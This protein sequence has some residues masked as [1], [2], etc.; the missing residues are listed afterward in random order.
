MFQLSMTSVIMLSCPNTW[1]FST[2][3]FETVSVFNWWWPSQALLSFLE[4]HYRFLFSCLSPPGD[5]WCHVLGF[6]PACSVSS[7][8]TLQ[9]FWDASHLVSLPTSLSAQSFPF[10]LSLLVALLGHMW[11]HYRHCDRHNHSQNYPVSLSTTRINITVSKHSEFA[12]WQLH[13]M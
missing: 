11:H 5:W 6:M 7:S 9:T 8:S 1:L 12:T 3:T 13:S 2:F 10:T 4:D